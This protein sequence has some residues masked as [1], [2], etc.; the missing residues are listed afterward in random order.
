MKQKNKFN[1]DIINTIISE[2]SCLKGEIHSQRSIRIEGELEGEINSQ[3][4]IYIGQNSK[5]KG[6]LYGK[7]VIV[8][9]E[10]IGNIE[11]IK[12]LQIQETGKVY[13][14]ITGDKL[15]IEEGGIYKGKV[16]MDIISSTNRYEGAIELKE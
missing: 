6:N 1:T 12:G 2:E 7:N 9:G 15:I 3:G 10:V 8:S 4:E 14:N 16:N 11:A 13:G 5:I